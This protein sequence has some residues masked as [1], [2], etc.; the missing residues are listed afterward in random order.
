MRNDLGEYSRYLYNDNLFDD[1]KYI[2][3]KDTIL[4]CIQILPGYCAGQAGGI[5]SFDVYSNTTDLNNYKDTTHYGE[6]I[7]SQMLSYMKA[8]IGLLTKENYR[9]YLDN[10]RKFYREFDYNSLFE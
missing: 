8:N 5:T 10:E 4:R 2:I 6:W 9:T 3:N 7:N 1:I